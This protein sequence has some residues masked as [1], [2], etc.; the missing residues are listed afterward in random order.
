M[1]K[2]AAV[3]GTE[4]EF[5]FDTIACYKPKCYQ[6]RKG[7]EVVKSRFKGVGNNDILY[8]N[9]TIPLGVNTALLEYLADWD[10]FAVF[11]DCYNASNDWET[12]TT[13]VDNVTGEKHIVNMWKEH[14]SKPSK[15]LYIS[16]QTY[17]PVLLAVIHKL[18]G[19]KNIFLTSP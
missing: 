4:E 10:L 7:D 8:A 15:D 9:Y 13:T 3:R 18:A 11:I 2:D 17:S 1:A 19:R 12:I 5:D 16:G 6:L 14:Y